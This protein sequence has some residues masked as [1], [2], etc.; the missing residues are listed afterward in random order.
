MPGP[1]PHWPIPLH[2]PPEV[3]MLAHAEHGHTPV[4]RFQ[5]PGLWSI[6]FYRYEA[7]LFVDGRHVCVYPRTV[8]VTP[9]A[10]VQ[11]YHFKQ[12]KCE[13]TYAHFRLPGHESTRGLPTIPATQDLGRRF[14]LLH[15]Q[16]REGID[17]FRASPGRASA[18]V[19]D[20][21]WQLADPPEAGADGDPITYHPALDDAVRLINLNLATPM[22]VAEIAK[23]V[24]VSNNQLTRLFR[25]RFD[26]TVV[27]FIRQRRMER[28]EHLLQHS[29][30][31]IRVIA[32]DV[33][34]PDLQLFNKT[35]RRELGSSPTQ[36][37][38]QA[39]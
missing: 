18:R 14:E 17:W 5:L 3:V 21:L 9:P 25:Q 39:E 8:G 20:V 35:V 34:L 33:G 16:F 19:W 1:T 13:H 30:L 36:I 24:G 37:R 32:R 22:R 29:T 28:A 12:P 11:E 31:P 4:E 38:K 2:S 15:N 10:A 27:A 6:H 23:A 26:N 7:E